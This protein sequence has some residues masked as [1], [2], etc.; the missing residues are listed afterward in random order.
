MDRPSCENRL[1]R[2]LLQAQDENGVT[3]LMLAAERGDIDQVRLLLYEAGMQDRRGRTALMYALT[4]RKAGAARLLWAPEVALA[5]FEGVS[6]RDYVARY[7][8]ED[9]LARVANYQQHRQASAR[10]AA[11]LRGADDEFIEGSGR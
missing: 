2:P 11:Q 4:A 7:R 10:A 1:V 6:A 9:P 3:A 8:M 5:D